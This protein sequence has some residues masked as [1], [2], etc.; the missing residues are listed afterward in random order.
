MA[1]SVLVTGAGGH[2]GGALVRELV[3]NG[4][5]VRASVREPS[6]AT[7]TQALWNLPVEVVAADLFDP[8]SLDA[9]C[10]GIDGVFQVAAIYD[11][12]PRDPARAR[13]LIDTGTH[14]TANLLSAA[15]KAGVGRVVLTSS[16]VTIAPVAPYQPPA[17]EDNWVSDTS[18]P[19]IEEKTR[20]EK[21]AWKRADELGLAMVSVLPGSVT[22]PGFN[23]STPSTGYVES[24]AKGALRLGAPDLDIP[25]VDV[26]DVATAHR[27]AF[28]KGHG[29]SRYI[30]FNETVSLYEAALTLHRIDANIGKP[31]MKMP[32]LATGM[33]PYIDAAMARLGG[34]RPSYTRAL[35]KSW[36]GR[37][38]RIDDSKS[39]AA[40]GFRPVVG[41]EQSLRDTLGQLRAI[42]RL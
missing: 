14:G 20:G 38:W 1:K 3:E 10:A 41:L 26:R 21:Q 6:D 34:Y 39:R 30:A 42:G 7:K 32:A 11:L 29:G 12:S 17:N 33:V 15:K 24:I 16:L 9:A 2:V 4:Y 40:L 8:G 13:A 37:Q 23:R 27:L 25:F 19:Y 35:H 28:E 36:K 22:G 31:L 5:N 18:V